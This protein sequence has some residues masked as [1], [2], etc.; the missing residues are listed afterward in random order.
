MVFKASINNISVISS[1]LL[2]EETGVLCVLTSL[3]LKLH[4]K[5]IWKKSVINTFC[6]SLHTEPL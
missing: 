1:V 6:T 4:V 2:M 5:C 3:S